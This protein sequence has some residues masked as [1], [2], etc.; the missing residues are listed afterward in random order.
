M[1]DLHCHILPGI[2]DGSANLDDALNLAR[3]AVSQGITHILCTP[4]H[5]NG[6]YINSKASVMEKVDELQK[7]LDLREIPLTLYEGQEVRIFPEIMNEINKNDILFC[8]VGDRYIL[9]EFPTREAPSYAIRVLGELLAAGKTPIIVHPE[10]NGTFIKDPNALIEYLD[11][12]CLAQL[13][14]PSIVGIFGKEIQQT[15]HD[16]VEHN[17][18]QMVASDAH[19]IKRRTFYLKE[20]YAE[21]LNKFGPEKVEAFEGISRRV[22]NGDDVIRPEF[23]KIG[24]KKG[25]LWF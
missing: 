5:H 23:S 9:I 16:M 22:L 14:A 12:G 10:R 17:L 19:H 6:K 8:D 15:A 21:I 1:L 11:M 25:F 18:V 7:E 4:H 13:T 20:A 2:D 3:K 24:Q